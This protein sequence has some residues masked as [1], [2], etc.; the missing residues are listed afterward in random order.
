[1][2][3]IPG[4]GY[5]QYATVNKQHLVRVPDG[6]DLEVAAAIPEVW[7]TAYQIMNLVGGG[8]SKNDYVLVHAA[9]S[10]VGTSILQLLRTYEAKAI[11]VASTDEKLEYAKSLGAVG[12]INYKKDPE[13]GDRVMSI[14]DGHGADMILDC[15]GGSHWEQ[16]EKSLARDGTWVNYGMMGGPAANISI[17]RVF[18]KRATI[19]FTSLRTRSVPYRAD[20][21]KKFE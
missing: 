2:G 3:I 6:L 21:A 16:N 19:K 11:A 18:A 5:G 17:G 9:V 14:T 4:G 7:M 20:L 10:G 8:V 15:V 13:F 12:G 1:M